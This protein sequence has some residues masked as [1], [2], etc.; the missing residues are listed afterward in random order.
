MGKIK[1]N[2]KHVS[3]ATDIRDVGLLHQKYTLIRHGQYMGLR[4]LAW[5]FSVLFFRIISIIMSSF[6]TASSYCL[7]Y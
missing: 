7:P 3:E 6:V 4:S 1:L 2:G 5:S